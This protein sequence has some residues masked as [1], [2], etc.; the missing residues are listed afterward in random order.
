MIHNNSGLELGKFSAAC[1]TALEGNSLPEM[2]LEI[3]G[4]L[5]FILAGSDPARFIQAKTLSLEANE[6]EQRLQ[7]R[8]PNQETRSP[9]KSDF[10][11]NDESHNSGSVEERAGAGFD[12]LATRL[13]TPNIL[14]L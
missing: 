14:F 11:V 12:L 7:A 6:P 10:N 9:L 5:G 4:T 1:K 13:H 3:T 8:A 2:D